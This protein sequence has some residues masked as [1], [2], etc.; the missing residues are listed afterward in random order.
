[1]N[2][3]WTGHR[4]AGWQAW[5][6]TLGPSFTCFMTLGKSLTLHEPRFPYVWYGGNKLPWGP[7]ETVRRAAGRIPRTWAFDNV[8]IIILLLNELIPAKSLCQS[9]RKEQ[10]HLSNSVFLSWEWLCPTLQ[11]DILQYLETFG[12]VITGDGGV[13]TGFCWVERL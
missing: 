6:W 2:P 3:S 5:M 12:V 11:G 7:N 13:A 10:S 4:L 1:M 9:N 8:N